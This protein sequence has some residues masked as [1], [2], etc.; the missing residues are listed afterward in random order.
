M[1]SRNRVYTLLTNTLLNAYLPVRHLL[2]EPFRD[3]GT[4]A[5]R[6]QPIADAVCRGDSAAAHAASERY[7]A[8]TALLM[9]ATLPSPS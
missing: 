2:A 6:L 5:G 4:A 9:K 1:A 7:M 8:D 3:A